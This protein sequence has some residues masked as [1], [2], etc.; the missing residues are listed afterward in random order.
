[1]LL[2]FSTIWVLRKRDCFSKLDRLEIPTGDFVASHKVAYV[3][4]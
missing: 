3:T 1:M 4:L 2:F